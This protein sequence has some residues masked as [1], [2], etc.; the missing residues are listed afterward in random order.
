MLIYLQFRVQ[1]RDHYLPNQSSSNL[2]DSQIFRERKFKIDTQTV[3]LCPNL[4]EYSLDHI[5]S[6]IVLRALSTQP[7]LQLAYGALSDQTCGYQASAK[8]LF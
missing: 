2:F 6:L 4:S 7:N 3:I 5:R 1:I 8:S